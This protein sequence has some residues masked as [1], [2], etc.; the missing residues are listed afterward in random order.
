MR[1]SW[2]WYLVPMV[3]L[4]ELGGQFLI[5][6]RAASPEEW[7]AIGAPV[8]QLVRPGDVL[9]VAPGWAEPLARHV[10][11]DEFWPLADLTRADQSGVSRVVEISLFGASDPSTEAW[12]LERQLSQGR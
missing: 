12:P 11:G 7:A 4:L 3:A 10:L 9:V 8:R 1:R 2:L 5:S 6:A